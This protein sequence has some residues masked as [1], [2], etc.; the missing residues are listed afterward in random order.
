MNK[1]Q[2]NSGGKK[3]RKNRL[4]RSSSSLLFSVSSLLLLFILPSNLHSQFR[5]HFVSLFSL[6]ILLFL[7]QFSPITVIRICVFF[8]LNFWILRLFFFVCID[9]NCIHH[10]FFR[11]CDWFISLFMSPF[12]FL[13]IVYYSIVEIENS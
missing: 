11:L 7:I 5:F 10:W 4:Y 12:W 3:Q 1:A 9:L 2:R 8:F 6:I 13:C